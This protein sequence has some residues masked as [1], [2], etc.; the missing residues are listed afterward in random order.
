VSLAEL[1]GKLSPDHP[2][3][4]NERSEDMLT[5]SIFGG[6][7]YLGW[8]SGL[9]GWLKESQLAWGDPSEAWNGKIVRVA[10]SFWPRLKNGRQPD[11]ALLILFDDRQPLVV[12]IEVKYGS[13]PSDWE[14]QGQT[15]ERGLTGNQIA[16]EI[17]GL[18]R[19][20]DSQ[21]LEW[22]KSDPKRE[23]DNSARALEIAPPPEPLR[24]IHLFVSPEGSRPSYH[25]LARSRLDARS[26]TIPA[27]W[28]SWTRLGRH[29]EAGIND[30]DPGRAA[31]SLDMHRLLQHRN[32]FPFEG[33]QVAPWS[34]NS[35]AS[36]WDGDAQAWWQLESPKLG[37]PYFWETK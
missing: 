24:R 28:L 30:S 33:F 4:I 29:V 19:M 7:R 11:V 23:S 9:I 34:S 22:F 32:L 3:S 25:E 5:S 2:E 8:E 1:H 13:G 35:T 15:D 20:T 37:E 16:D 18:R 17:R 6:F 21:I 14:I 26:A 27:Y 12:A 31:L 10:Y 36:F